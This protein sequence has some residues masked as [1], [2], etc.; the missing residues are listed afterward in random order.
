MRERVN[1]KDL[2]GLRQQMFGVR[3]SQRLRIKDVGVPETFQRAEVAAPLMDES[4]LL[5]AISVTS[6]DEQRQFGLEDAELL[7][8]LAGLAAATMVGHEEARLD[9][10]LLSALFGNNNSN[11]SPRWGMVSPMPFTRFT[12]TGSASCSPTAL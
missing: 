4:R 5:G 3:E 11:A 1:G 12:A 9:G 2:H 6:R 8:V 10:V 7:E